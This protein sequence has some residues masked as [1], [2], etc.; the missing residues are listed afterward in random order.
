MEKENLKTITSKD[1]FNKYNNIVKGI[2]EEDLLNLVD[3]LYKDF[4]ELKKKFLEDKHLNNIKMDLIDSNFYNVR[5][6][7][8]KNKTSWSLSEGC[9]TQKHILIYV[10]LGVKPIFKEDIL[11]YD[12]KKKEWLEIYFEKG[13]KKYSNE[14]TYFKEMGYI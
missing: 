5:A 9:S 2:S 14:D 7:C 13:L 3:G 12:K 1:H 4:E 11:N 6:L 10:V 8:S